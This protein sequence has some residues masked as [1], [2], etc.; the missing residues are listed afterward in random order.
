MKEHELLEAVGGINSRYVEESETSYT[1]VKR[2]DLFRIPRVATAA[3]AL[4]VCMTGITA[5]A[6][7]GVLQGFFKD[8]FS[9]N[10]AVIGTEYE[11]ASDELN[12]TADYNDGKLIVTVKAVDPSMAPYSEM[13]TLRLNSYKIVDTSGNV[14]T[15][16][17]SSEPVEI[18]NGEAIIVITQLSDYE[19]E[20]QLIIS[21]FEGGKK[22]DQP[23]P[24]SGEWLCSFI[25]SK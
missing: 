2:F 12:V 13:E 10:G 18:H 5:L 19:G 25:I 6:A 1:A 24:I 7:T 17:Q 11:N 20:Y 9:W 16:N 15:D 22:A 14:I 8:I 21:E 3:I 4:C 23:L